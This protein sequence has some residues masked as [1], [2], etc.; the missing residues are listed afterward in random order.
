MHWSGCAVSEPGDP[1][2]PGL[3]IAKAGHKTTGTIACADPTRTGKGPILFA[4][5]FMGHRRVH[6]IDFF[7][8]SFGAKCCVIP[9]SGMVLPALLAIACRRQRTNHTAL[10]GC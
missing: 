5:S 2:T 10:A 9:C 8:L 4:K 3:Y 6:G 1:H 7:N